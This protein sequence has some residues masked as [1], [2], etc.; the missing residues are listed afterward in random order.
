M[1]Y[2]NTH[3][4]R[5]A[6]QQTE[7]SMNTQTIYEVQADAATGEWIREPKATE[8]IAELAEFLK[9]ADSDDVAHTTYESP[10]DGSTR[11]L[12]VVWQQ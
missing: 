12:R 3:G 2:I 11:L 9:R 4:Q 1:P 8:E 5:G 7:S 10:F 6:V